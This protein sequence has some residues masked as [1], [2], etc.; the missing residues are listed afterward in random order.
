MQFAFLLQ[1]LNLVNRRF[2]YRL[3]HTK[4][5]FVKMKDGKVLPDI[6]KNLYVTD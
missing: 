6:L 3:L 2:F 1:M 5:Q 4:T